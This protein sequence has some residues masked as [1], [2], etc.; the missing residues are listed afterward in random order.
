MAHKTVTE[1]V[2]SALM[3]GPLSDV[4]SRI[5][6]QLRDFFA[7]KCQ[8]YGAKNNCED[9]MIDFFNSIFSEISP[10]R[11]TEETTSEASMKWIKN[12]SKK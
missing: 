4:R 2:D 11:N 12:W 1:T 8:I 3:I 7:H 5:L 6:G 10:F 9:T